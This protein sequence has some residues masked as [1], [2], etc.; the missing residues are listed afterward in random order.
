MAQR[1]WHTAIHYPMHGREADMLRN[2][3]FVQNGSQTANATLT[4]C[5]HATKAVRNDWAQ[6]F[7]DMRQAYAAVHMMTPSGANP[8][9][10]QRLVYFA[11]PCTGYTNTNLSDL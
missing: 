1:Y 3:Q 5:K 4:I 6:G 9:R 11:P 2:M 8:R 10:K 7:C